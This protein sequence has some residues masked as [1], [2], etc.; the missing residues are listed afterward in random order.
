MLDCKTCPLS[1]RGGAL[2][3]GDYAME[4]APSYLD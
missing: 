2:V 1:L 3:I 4:Q